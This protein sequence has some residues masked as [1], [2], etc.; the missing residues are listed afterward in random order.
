MCMLKMF[1]YITITWGGLIC[2]GTANFLQKLYPEI[3]LNLLICLQVLQ[4]LKSCMLQLC[5]RL[6]ALFNVRFAI[7]KKLKAFM[8][9][10]S[11]LLVLSIECS[12]T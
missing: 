2:D 3:L 11:Q 7:A 12:I 4:K 6:C 10:S 9:F 8:E 5:C 1:L